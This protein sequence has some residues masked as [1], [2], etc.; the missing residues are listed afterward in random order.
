MRTISTYWLIKLRCSETKTCT[1]TKLIFTELHPL[2]QEGAKYIGIKRKI[3]NRFDTKFQLHSADNLCLLVEVMMYRN[4]NLDRHKA[5]FQHNCT[6]KASDSYEPEEW[7]KIASIRS[8]SQT[9]RTISAYWWLKLLR[10]DS[11]TCA[12]ESYFSTQL[13]QKR[14]DFI[15]N[16]GKIENRL[17]W[18]T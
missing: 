6:T 4:Q 1:D 15:R 17:G 14:I 10:S 16:N 2:H 7:S 11:K 9:V 5:H 18:K 12:H 13:H 3:E 8:S